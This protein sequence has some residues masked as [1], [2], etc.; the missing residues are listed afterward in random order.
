MIDQRRKRGTDVQPRPDGCSSGSNAR[1]GCLVNEWGLALVVGLFVAGA[2]AV[3]VALSRTKGAEQ[4][5]SHHD[6]APDTESERLYGGSD[7]P[8]GPDAEDDPIL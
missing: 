7:R 8:A 5:A 6:E 1:G 2:V 3:V 4:A